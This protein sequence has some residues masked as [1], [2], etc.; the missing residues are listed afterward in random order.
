MQGHIQKITEVILISMRI[1][2]ILPYFSLVNPPV[3]PEV[4]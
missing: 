1:A 3:G 2:H 4:S